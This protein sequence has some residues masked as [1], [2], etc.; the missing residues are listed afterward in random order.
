MNA[1]SLSVAAV[2]GALYAALV[3]VLQPISFLA[4][5]VRLADALLPLSMVLGVPAAV[6]VSVGCFFG[7]LVAAPWGSLALGLFDAVFGSLANFAASYLAYIVAYNKGRR[8]K[9]A[10]AV[11][12]AVV[13]S[14]IVGFYLKYLLLWA[15]GVDMP[16]EAV[17]LGVLAGSVVSIIAIGYPLAI[18]V[19]KP[20]KNLVKE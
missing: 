20:L 8:A 16:L 10:G 2:L 5:Q 15:M 18:L 6:G 12:E 14:G 13:V 11:L 1:K 9:L 4:F 3:I 17:F 19:E 7:N